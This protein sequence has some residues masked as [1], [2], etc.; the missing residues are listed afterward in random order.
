MW[1]LTLIFLTI[2]YVFFKHLARFHP[3]LETVLVMNLILNY[4]HNIH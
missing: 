1:C 2:N 3:T 4:E